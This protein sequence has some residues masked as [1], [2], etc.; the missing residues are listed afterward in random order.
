MNLENFADYLKYPSRLYQL[1]YEELKSLTMQYPYCSNFHVLLLIKSKLES[2]PDLEKN[3]AKAATYCTDR[4]FLRKIMKEEAPLQVGTPFTIGE[5]EVLELKDLFTLESQL[6]KIPV[7]P[8]T[9]TEKDTPE[10]ITFD[11]FPERTID[12][13]EEDPE[14]AAVEYPEG[15]NSEA[16]TPEATPTG[17]YSAEP[18]LSPDPDLSQIVPEEVKDSA[19]IGIPDAA[20]TVQGYTPTPELVAHLGTVLSITANWTSDPVGTEPALIPTPGLPDSI[21][22]GCITVNQ[23]VHEWWEQQGNTTSLEWE[24]PSFTSNASVSSTQQ[25]ESNLSPTP[26]SAFNSYRKRYVKP[27]R[28]GTDAASPVLLGKN[29]TGPPQRA[30][31]VAAES[32]REDLGVASETL[33][34][35]LVQQHQYDRAIK[36]YEHLSL[37]IPEKNTYFAAKIDEIKKI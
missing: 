3:L 14:N 21:L 8:G 1:P 9:P 6:E 19:E 24:I 20:A 2:H 4:K 36:M 29:P 27:L 34:G 5:D 15:E 33:A 28:K 31:K 17:S 23:L 12:M 25:V 26:K 18:L 22:A 13:Q 30:K 35:L 37:L 10:N 32:I 7:S 16:G 11:L